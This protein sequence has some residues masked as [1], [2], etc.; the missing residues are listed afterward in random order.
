MTQ[1]ELTR[2]QRCHAELS[3]GVHDVSGGVWSSG[4]GWPVRAT[5]SQDALLCPRVGHDGRDPD[6]RQDA[7][8]DHGGITI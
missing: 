5:S 4:L 1:L 3:E 8:M 2:N 7:E 6:P